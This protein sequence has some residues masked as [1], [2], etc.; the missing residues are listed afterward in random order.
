MLILWIVNRE[1]VSIG[2]YLALENPSNVPANQ[3][4]AINTHTHKKDLYRA[5]EGLSMVSKTF[6][7]FFYPPGLGS[8][9]PTTKIVTLA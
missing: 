4:E 6:K 5:F 2:T 3:L 8:Q 7:E 1:T 9:Q